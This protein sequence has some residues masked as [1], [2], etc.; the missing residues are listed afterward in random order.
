LIA[1]VDQLGQSIGGLTGEIHQHYRSEITEK[2]DLGDGRRRIGLRLV[3]DM[4]NPHSR[5]RRPAL[6]CTVIAPWD[7]EDYRECRQE[8]WYRI[9]HGESLDIE[10]RADGS[11]LR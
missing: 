5:L 9:E 2:G 11:A 1:I 6:Y 3:D 10:L 8:I 7:L 4:Q